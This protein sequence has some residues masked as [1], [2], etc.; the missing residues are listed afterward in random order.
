MNK[1]KSSVNVPVF[2]SSDSR[3]SVGNFTYGNPRLMIWSENERIE[4][5]SFC[6][7]GDNVTIFAGGEHNSHWVTTYP[8]RI[9]FGD[10]L[11]NKDGHPASKGPTRIGHDVWIGF[12]VTVLSGVTIGNGAIL[13]ACSVV[14]KDVPPYHIVVGNPARSIRQRFS[15]KHIK[16]LSDIQWWNWPIEKIKKNSHLLCDSNINEFI[17]KFS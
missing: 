13:G 15:D 14:T 6:S 16:K 5:G 9:A 1:M 12:G 3:V 11:A 7:I 17:R 2:V 10:N 4:I 8:L